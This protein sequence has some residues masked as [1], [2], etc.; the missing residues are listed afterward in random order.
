MSTTLIPPQPKPSAK[1]LKKGAIPA[2]F[3]A[4]LASPFAHQTLERM[5][6]NILKVYEDHLANDIPTYCAGRTDWKAPIGKSLTSDECKDVNAVTLLEYGY[7]ILECVNWDYLN[8]SR[9]IGLTA[10]AI[11]VG[12]VGACNSAAVREINQGN[13][14]RGCNFIAYKQDG[15]P[16]WSYANGVFVNGLFNRR[17][18]ERTLCL[19]QSEEIPNG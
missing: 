12:K 6:G 7:A 1:L 17:K 13:I 16:N 4:A 5:E 19:S 9:L 18:A 14:V 3:L 15:T 10:F 8:A 2:V 11:N